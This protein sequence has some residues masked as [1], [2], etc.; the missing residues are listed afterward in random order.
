[1]K[2]DI[3]TFFHFLLFKEV[4]KVNKVKKYFMGIDTSNYTSS[5]AIVDENNNVIFD[6]RIILNVKI[7]ERGLRQSDALFQHIN[8]VP[9][10][11]SKMTETIDTNQIKAISVSSQPRAL[12]DS[13]MPV[14]L[15]GKSFGKSLSDVLKCNYY[16]F[17]HQ[18]GHLKAA[19]YNNKIKKQNFKGMQISGGTTEVLSIDTNNK[20]YIINIIGE[21]KDI[22]IGQLIDRIGV[23]LGYEFPC[24]KYLDKEASAYKNKYEKKLKKIHMEDLD[25]NLSGIE[26]QCMNLINNN[27]DEKQIIHELFTKIADML[28]NIIIKCTENDDEFILMGGVAS[29]EF[30]R[31]RISN[32]IKLKNKS[33][34]FGEKEYSLDNAVGTALLGKEKEEGY[35]YE[36]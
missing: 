35:I 32:D 1:M 6:D 28:V 36:T 20:D 34:Y 12:D 5:V 25:I 24:G 14:F 9:Y 29:S 26:T 11:I 16:E 17:S 19:M 4:D 30:I 27:I 15:A 18:Q 21:T 13:Y 31:N 23:K 7:G 10:I 3:I 2:K 8:N 22:S 33:I